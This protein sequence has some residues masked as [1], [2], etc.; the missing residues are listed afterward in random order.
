M[1]RKYVPQ[2][3]EMN[4]RIKKYRILYD[5]FD[6]IDGKPLKLYDNI[7][8]DS[9][10]HTPRLNRSVVKTPSKSKS[11]AQS[12]DRTKTPM[13]LTDDSEYNQDNTCMFCGE[14]NEKFLKQGFEMHYWKSCPMLRQCHNCKQV[15]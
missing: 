10:S 6:T 12:L 4:R 15:Y 8:G 13:S 5:A 9:G 14:V 11:R 7:N 3:S 2:D 1:V